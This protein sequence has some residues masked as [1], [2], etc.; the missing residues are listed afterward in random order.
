[1]ATRRVSW[2]RRHLRNHAYLIDVAYAVNTN[3]QLTAG[4]EKLNYSRNIG[5]VLQWRAASSRWMRNSCT[6]C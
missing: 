6:R 2:A 5:I 1:M 4:W 3:L